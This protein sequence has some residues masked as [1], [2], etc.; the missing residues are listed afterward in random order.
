MKRTVLVAA[1]LHGGPRDG[2]DRGLEHDPGGEAVAA[3]AADKVFT[4]RWDY[5]MA[6]DIYFA[7]R[8]QPDGR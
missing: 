7:R 6:G 4:A 5:D 1:N 2:P 8:C 3:D